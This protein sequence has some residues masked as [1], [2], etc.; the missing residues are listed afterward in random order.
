MS[1]KIKKALQIIDLQD[2]KYPRLEVI[3]LYLTL[4]NFI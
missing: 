2:F 4:F 1:Q 3:P